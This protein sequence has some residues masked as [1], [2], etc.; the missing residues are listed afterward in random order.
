MQQFDLFGA[1]RPDALELATLDRLAFLSDEAPHRVLLAAQSGDVLEP[2]APPHPS[3]RRLQI[4]RLITADLVKEGG[5]NLRYTARSAM[6]KEVRRG[7]VLGAARWARLVA[8]IDGPQATRQYA[9]RIVLEETRA[10]ACLLEWR[11]ARGLSGERLI[12]AL[13]AA[14]KKWLLEERVRADCE[15]LRLLVY[16]AALRA[17][18]LTPAEIARVV[19][20]Q[21]PVLE[22]AYRL[23]WRVQLTREAAVVTH[24]R[25][26]LLLRAQQDGDEEAAALAQG[27][28]PYLAEALVERLCGVRSAEASEIPAEAEQPLEDVAL[29][30]PPL[31]AYVYDPHTRPGRQRLVQHLGQLRPE[32]PLPP[33]LELRWSGMARG[34]AW[35]AAAVAQAGAAGLALPWEAVV[36]PAGLWDAAVQI[37]GFFYDTLCR[38]AGLT[39]PLPRVDW[40]GS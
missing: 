36:I 8:L 39:L 30:V 20:A 28:E 19:E 13:A 29:T 37:D 21:Q 10:V 38:E 12:R 18:T 1:L 27:S 26:A 6:H 4:L 16:P 24:L 17:G 3:E 9:R 7:D 15:A 34:A 22:D 25:E 35:R 33:G 32:R 5:K 11:G 40:R 2:S 23:L 14:P 31:R